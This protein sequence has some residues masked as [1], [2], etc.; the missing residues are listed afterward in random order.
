MFGPCLNYFDAEE[1]T[2]VKFFSHLSDKIGDVKTVLGS[3]EEK[4][5]TNALKKKF[6]IFR[7]FFCVPIT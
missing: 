4:S 5:L 6:L 2:N 7:N 3:D 1:S